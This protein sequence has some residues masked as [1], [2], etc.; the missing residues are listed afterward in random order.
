MSQPS[1]TT[2]RQNT[3]V[4][5]TSA[6]TT[7]RSQHPA[8]LSLVGHTPLLRLDRIAPDLSKSVEVY[9]KAEW[10]NPGSSVKDRP[11]LAMILD[12]ERTGHLRPD[13]RIAD[14]TS[15]NTGIA[16]ATLGAALG[17]GVTLAMPAKASPERK[18]T[19]EVLGA[20]LIL[21]D[22]Q[23]GMDRDI[24]TIS[25]LVEPHPD[26]FF[27]P[28]QYNNPA[29]VQ[30]HFDTTGAEI[31]SQTAGRITHF[32]AALGTCGPFVGTGRRLRDANQHMQ[33]IGVQTDGPYHA[34][35]GVKHV[36]TTNLV[37]GIYDATLADDTI[38]VSS[39]AAFDMA[40][41][42]ARTEGLLIGI[43]AAANVVAALRL[44]QTLERGVVVTILCDSAS[45]Y[46]SETFWTDVDEACMSGAGI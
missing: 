9:A 8:V 43:S 1:S 5:H 27:Y 34:L 21:T 16:C 22:P 30:A 36:A 28:D 12:G 13:M 46:L 17:Y 39:E 42:L 45:K 7:A 29:N 6:T 20:D 32:V 14:A 24:A 35:K 38:E 15:G 44:A 19:L 2:M 10:Y 4:Q 31:W 18:R 23:E 25:A 26:R 11:T 3:D 37:P 41:R 33:L 40:R